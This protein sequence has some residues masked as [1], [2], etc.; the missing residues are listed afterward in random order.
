MY[1]TSHVCFF[2]TDS[3]YKC[4]VMHT[5]LGI[6]DSFSAV[7]PPR[8]KPLLPSIDSW[9]LLSRLKLLHLLS[10]RFSWSELLLLLLLFRV[11]MA[12]AAS[13]SASCCP[14]LGGGCRWAFMA[15][16]RDCSRPSCCSSWE[17]IST[18][19]G[20]RNT[21]LVWQP[22]QT[23]TWI[24]WCLLVFRSC[25]L[26]ITSGTSRLCAGKSSQFTLLA[27]EITL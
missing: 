12:V 19:K 25:N 2:P 4:V 22:H 16:R 8:L 13:W 6:L 15:S 5:S 23:I 9:W 17:T 20:V 1:I 18:W 10:S 3:E 27:C 14:A 24:W 26:W 7:W 11:A 21:K